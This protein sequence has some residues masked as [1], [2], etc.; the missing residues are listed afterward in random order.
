ML[1]RWIMVVVG[2]FWEGL[3][4]AAGCRLERAGVF[5]SGL[6][7]DVVMVVAVRRDFESEGRGCLG[8]NWSWFLWC[9]NVV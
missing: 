4:L 7:I 6:S 1:L 2:D 9:S 8:V 5:E 3:W